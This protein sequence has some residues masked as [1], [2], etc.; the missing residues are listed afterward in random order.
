MIGVLDWET[1]MA[2]TLH[3]WQEGAFPVACGLQLEGGRYQ[4][5]WFK[6][7]E[8]KIEDDPTEI[9]QALLNVDLLVGHNLKFDLNW[10]TYMGVEYNGKYWC[11]Q[12]SEYLLGGQKMFGLKLK[13]VA[14]RRGQPAKLDIV[15]GY[16]DRGVNTDM[17]PKHILAEYLK[18]DCDTTLHVYLDQLAEMQTE[19]PYLRQI[20]TVHNNT[21]SILT[22]IECNGMPIDSKLLHSM[23][24]KYKIQLD[25][26]DHNLTMMFGRDDLN[27]QSKD[28]LSAALYGGIIHR[29]STEMVPKERWATRKVP[30]KF[31][32]KDGSTTMKTRN[33][34]YREQYKV[35]RKCV[36]DIHI[37]GAGF[38]TDKSM[39]VAKDGYF[40]TGIAIIK[41]LK[42]GTAVRREIKKEL[43]NRAK[44][45]KLVSSV[46]GSEPGKGY[47][48]K[49]QKDGRM[50]PQYNQSRTGTGRYSSQDPNGQNFPRSKEDQEGFLN[51]LKTVFVPSVAPVAG[52]L[53]AA[54]DLAQLEWRVAAFLSQDPIAMNEIISGIDA[55]ADNATRFFGDIKFRQDAKIMTFRLL[56]GGTAYS[57]FMDPLMPNFSLK[58]WTKIVQDYYSKYHVLAAW[59]ETNIQKVNANGGW[60]VSQ[61]G[62]L[63]NFPLSMIKKN[64][65]TYEGYKPTQ[66]KNYEV[67]GTA[68]GDIMP[69]T[70]YVVK[71]R[72]ADN[73]PRSKWIG[74]IH[75]AILFDTVKAEIERLSDLVI[76]TFEDLPIL[77]EKFWKFEFNVPLTGDMEFGPNYGLMPHKASR[78]TIGAATEFHY[79]KAA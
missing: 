53:I 29:D 14:E 70:M 71:Q 2:P 25:E 11:T 42:A 17:I 37:K 21:T 73:F 4:D 64:G 10:L 30:F 60:Y 74:Q 33:E 51:P 77:I 7:N 47:V 40:K 28:E 45:S 41:N 23:G 1:S 8:V 3:P 9:T 32:Y 24:G 58:R 62:R 54:G 12:T 63:Y 43:I 13:E 56:Y 26:I 76:Q 55:H 36:E 35:E 48:N 34:K 46:L 69:F 5:W 38:Q 20:M 68:T 65:I 18:Q 79:A 66:I 22:D 59:Q 15:E 61:F 57:F 44:I 6:H 19:K 72:M 39:Q 27:L 31:T 50:H 75:D 52:G 16:W 49:V 67:Q 78:P